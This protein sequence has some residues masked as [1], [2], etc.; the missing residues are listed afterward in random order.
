[1]TNKSNRHII[2]TTSLLQTFLFAIIIET[3]TEYI[4]NGIFLNL[5]LQY[6]YID[7]EFD[8]WEQN[9]NIIINNK[10]KK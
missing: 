8:I 10:I 6:L 5:A 1:M 3:I 4:R 2:I 9:Q 7:Y